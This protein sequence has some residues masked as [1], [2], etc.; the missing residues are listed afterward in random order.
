MKRYKENSA[1]EIINETGKTTCYLKDCKRG[2]LF[3]RN[4]ALCMVVESSC[5]ATAPDGMEDPVLIINLGTG[6]IW[7]VT[8]E[9][10]ILDKVAEA[11]L[12]FS[13]R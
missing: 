4:G 13:T 9:E 3:L 12:T 7:Y 2:D 6:R 8:G 1:L 10:I 11:K 5:A